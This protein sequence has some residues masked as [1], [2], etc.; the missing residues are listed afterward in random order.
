[1]NMKCREVWSC[2]RKNRKFRGENLNA[3]GYTYADDS[4]VINSNRLDVLP[5]HTL[6]QIFRKEIERGIEEAKSCLDHEDRRRLLCRVDPEY[7]MKIK[8]KTFARACDCGVVRV[9]QYGRVHYHFLPGSVCEQRRK[10][11]ALRREAALREI[12][13]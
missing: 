11:R 1:M 4:D 8:D 12:A 13:S 5:R 2:G 10:E 3:R 7:A 9:D 6:R